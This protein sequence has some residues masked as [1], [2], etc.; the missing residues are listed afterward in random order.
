MEEPRKPAWAFVVL[1][2]LAF[3]V[4]AIYGIALWNS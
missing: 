4:L 1:C 3:W 2:C